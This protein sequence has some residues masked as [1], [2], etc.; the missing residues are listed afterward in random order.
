MRLM[1]SAPGKSIGWENQL[2]QPRAIYKT[3]PPT[4]HN[5]Q[6]VFSHS[7][8]SYSQS[9]FCSIIQ[10]W[11]QSFKVYFSSSMFTSAYNRNKHLAIQGLLQ[12]T[13]ATNI[14]PFKG[15]FSHS[16]FT[17]TYNKNIQRLFQPCSWWG[18]HVHDGQ[19]ASLGCWGHARGERRQMMIEE[20]KS[21]EANVTWELASLPLATKQSSSN[22][23]SKSSKTGSGTFHAT[24]PILW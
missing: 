3:G 16:R 21:I 7:R 23:S 17:S 4:T 22:G 10:D 8:F 11:L 14:Q 5:V 15:Y 1:G 12:H 20:M 2:H 6:Q 9:R 13:I 19:W 18:A 24:R